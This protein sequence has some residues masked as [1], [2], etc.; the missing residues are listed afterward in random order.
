M[1]P[2][3]I[4]DVQTAL[5]KLLPDGPVVVGV[6]G[7]VDSLVLLDLLVQAGI[8]VFV[9]HVNYGLRA[10]ESNLDEALVRSIT[11]RRRLPLEAVPA[12]A[13]GRAVADGTSLQAAARAIRY[14]T[15]VRVA[16]EKGARCIA[17]GHHAEDQSETVLLQLL[18]GSGPEGLAGMRF[19]RRVAADLLLVRPLLHVRRAELVQYAMDREI[20]W[21]EDSSNA[22]RSYRRSLIRHDV[23]PLLDRAA[24]GDATAGIVTSAGLLAEYSRDYLR[25]ELRRRFRSVR[26]RGERSLSLDPLSLQPPVWQG[27]IVMRAVRRWTNAEARRTVVQDILRMVDAQVG[28]SR[29]VGD[30]VVWR[31]RDRLAFK[32][33]KMAEGFARAVLEAWGSEVPVPGGVIRVALAG[34][35][36][37]ERTEGDDSPLFTLV[38]HVNADSLRFPLIIRPWR[39]GDRIRP[40]GMDGTKKVSDILTDA[41]V[42]SAE[43]VHRLVMEA[44]G[45]IIWIVGQRI[46][47]SI[48]RTGETG[49]RIA[50]LV[51]DRQDTAPDG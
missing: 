22:D 6:S 32:R 11:E 1:I 4:V 29:A 12:D 42:P 41:R 26:I 33:D 5:T 44:E 25:R 49:E 10:E 21:R 47:A 43:R 40:L 23:M 35:T 15:F 14:E 8:E 7:G 27:R 2:G 9:V 19:K 17:V 39:A 28:R 51:Y 50:R 16:R 34:A 20:E 13:R 18:R 31:E 36:D 37:V 46:A 48:A 30:V 45:E 24:G 3:T 38:E